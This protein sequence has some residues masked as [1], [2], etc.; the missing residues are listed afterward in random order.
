M[1]N[2]LTKEKIML[3]QNQLNTVICSNK[4][5]I[6]KNISKIEALKKEN[7]LR[8]SQ[9]LCQNLQINFK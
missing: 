4:E 7:S 5:Y 6:W 2:T 9:T 8:K 3:E 1:D